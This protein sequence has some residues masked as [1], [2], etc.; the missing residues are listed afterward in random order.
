MANQY[1]IFCWHCQAEFDALSAPDCSHAS[2]TKICPFCLKCFCDASKEYKKKYLKNGPKELLVEYTEAKSAQYLKIGEILVKAGKISI[3]QLNT[4]LDKQRIVNKKLGEVLIMMSLVT[5]DELQ[6]YLLNQKRVE[7]IDLKNLKVDNELINQIGRDFCLDQKIVPIEIQEIAGGRMLRFAFYSIGEL[8]K[9]KKSGELQKFKLIPYLAPKEEIENMLKNMEASEKE[10]KIYTSLADARYLKLLNSLIKAA[11]QNKVSD[12]LF[13][14]KA[15]ELKLFFRKGDLLSPVDLAVENHEGFFNKVKEICAIKPT[16]KNVPH[17]SFLNLN[18][19]LSHLKIKVLFYSGSDQENICFKISN[20]NDFSKK[21]SDLYLEKEE[22]DRLRA[23]LE[24]PSGLFI[25]AGPAYSK[26]NETLYAL[27]NSLALER[28]AT[29]ENDVILRKETFFQIEN[30]DIDVTNAVYKNLLFYKPDSMFLFE[31]FQKN[32]DSQ[33]LQFVEMGKLFIELQGFSYEEIFEKLIKEYDVPISYLVENL[34]VMIFQ[35]QAKILCPVCKTPDPRPAQELFKNKNLSGQFRIFQEKGC[36]QCKSSG[37][38]R[39]EIFFEI[40][41]MDNL[42][43]S[44]FKEK[45]LF[46]LDK[47]ITENGNLTISQKILNRV[48]KGEISYQESCRFF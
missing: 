28:I 10:I 43:R 33:F 21:I 48:L 14:I 37:Y 9:L 47:K 38:G 39:E 32:Y 20:L 36:P 44:Q 22:L 11:V 46:F 3:G 35:R 30:Q 6:L 27:M 7:T 24:K 1:L 2:P 17:E 8:P 16:A 4:A 26:V 18:K 25:V 15:G 5:P 45:Q 41:V 31:Y 12:V 23:I 29:V 19:N 34:R 13:E 42:E 40:F